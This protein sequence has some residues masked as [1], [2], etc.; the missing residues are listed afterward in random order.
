MAV[1]RPDLARHWEQTGHCAEGAMPGYLL[2]TRAVSRGWGVGSVP[3]N[4]D[5]LPWAELEGSEA[6]SQPG[7]AP[8]SAIWVPPLRFLPY[9]LAL[10]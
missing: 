9:K 6:P 5:S 3:E 7:T 4:V 8:T 1:G 2:G 10:L